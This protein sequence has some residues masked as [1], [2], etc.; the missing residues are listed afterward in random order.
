MTT[1]DVLGASSPRHH[2]RPGRSRLIV[3]VALALGLF[4]AGCGGDD[5]DAE[6]ADATST[7]AGSTATTGGATTTAASAE[8]EVCTADKKGGE[9]TFSAFLMTR[10]FD[11]VI[12]TGSGTT[13][14]VEMAAVYDMLIRWNGETRKYEPKLAK[15]LTPNA[16]FTEWTMELRPEAKFGNGDPVDATA[17][18]G[19]LERHLNPNNFSTVYVDSQVISSIDVVSQWKL[20]FKLKAPWGTFPFYLSDVAGLVVNPKVFAPGRDEAHGLAP[21]GAGRAPTR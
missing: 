14:S 15:S 18:K 8:D 20:V 16:T 13:G 7:S 5:D 10:S 19:S 11:P 9:I 4:A 6:G 3:T 12:S 2:R 17:V 21:T 1:N